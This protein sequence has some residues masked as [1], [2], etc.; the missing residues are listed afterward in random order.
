MA[1][2]C[3]S[4]SSLTNERGGIHIWRS[5]NPGWEAA[6]KLCP[7]FLHWPRQAH[8]SLPALVMGQSLEFL[9]RH[10]FSCFQRFR[11]FPPSVFYSLPVDQIIQISTCLLIDFLLLLHTSGLYPEKAMSALQNKA[12]KGIM[13]LRVKWYGVVREHIAKPKTNRPYLSYGL[14]QDIPCSLPS[15]CLQVTCWLGQNHTSK[16]TNKLRGA[17][18]EVEQDTAPWPPWS[19]TGREM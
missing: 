10:S 15:H 3:N 18:R 13:A 1:W 7:R 16:S 19:H 5:R 4:S 14:G 6:E 9:S 8:L 2:Q 12:S 17:M 11:R